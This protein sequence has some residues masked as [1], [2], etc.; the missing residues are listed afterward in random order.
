M[1]YFYLKTD[2]RNNVQL[3]RHS[4]KIGDK[5]I[6]FREARHRKNDKF[7]YR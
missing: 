1:W 7:F 4:L 6:V 3:A 2:L 5:A